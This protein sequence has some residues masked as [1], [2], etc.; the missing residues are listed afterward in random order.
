MGTELFHADGRTWWTNSRFS[1]FCERAHIGEESLRKLI[2][3]SSNNH[4]P[5][6]AWIKL[7][8]RDKSKYNRQRDLMQE[9]LK[10]ELRNLLYL[11]SVC[12]SPNSATKVCTQ[13]CQCVVASF[14]RAL[15]IWMQCYVNHDMRDAH[16]STQDHLLIM[17]KRD[18]T[19]NI[20][21]CTRFRSWYINPV[22]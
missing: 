13:G 22:S 20:S 15:H 19:V 5:P 12:L 21:E 4:F 14:L 6:F 17:Q 11:S 3:E 10:R 8:I 9:L 1:Q 16:I 2:F 7:S 18:V